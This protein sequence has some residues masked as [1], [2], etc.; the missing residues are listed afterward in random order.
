LGAHIDHQGGDVLGMSI[1]A[2][3]LLAFVQRGD[4][5]VVIHS[6][7]FPEEAARFNVDDHAKFALPAD[8]SWWKYAVGAAKT[9]AVNEHVLTRGFT[10]AV[11][12]KLGSAGVSSS[13]SV[14]IAYL[15]ALAHCNG[16]SLSKEQLVEYDRM[17]EN[18]Y[19]GLKNG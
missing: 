3:S 19:L 10:G 11:S 5:Q 6:E 13:A 17:I 15:L 1:T 12:G 8:R 4:N 14:G 18:N 16:L 2:G 9:L 7:Q